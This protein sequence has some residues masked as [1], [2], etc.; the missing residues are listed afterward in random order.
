MKALALAAC[1]AVLISNT[2]S[3]SIYLKDTLSDQVI[4]PLNCTHGTTVAIA[5]TE[6]K[7]LRP[8]PR[9]NEILAATKELKIRYLDLKEADM[10]QTVD[11]L[12]KRVSQQGA[13]DLDFVFK[14]KSTYSRTTRYITVSIRRLALYD[15]LNAICEEGG[16]QWDIRNGSIIIEPSETFIE[17][18]I[19]SASEN[20]MDSL[21]LLKNSTSGTSYG[22]YALKD[23]T[24]I[25]L[26][27]SVFILRM[28]PSDAQLVS[29]LK[30]LIIPAFNF[31]D[32]E[33]AKYVLYLN[34]EIK[35]LQNNLSPEFQIHLA[36]DVIAEKAV[37]TVSLHEK[38]LYDILGTVCELS[39]L[40]WDIQDGNIVLETPKPSR[41]TTEKPP[42]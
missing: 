4:G 8:D 22:P 26:D 29:S 7:L 39:R 5:G 19:R 17:P 11:N 2:W 13:N 18:A 14:K 3:E 12:S 27:E 30:K 42:S 23:Q 16:C 34:E 24:S 33:P 38:S 31:N 10:E 35:R 32:C 21:F 25:R 40:Q 1:M 15:S 36:R 6:Y 41:S 37:I 28:R 9:Y 20:T